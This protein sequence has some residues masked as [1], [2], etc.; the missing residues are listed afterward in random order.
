MKI[1]DYENEIIEKFFPNY[2]REKSFIAFEVLIGG[3]KPELFIVKIYRKGRF[4]Y[5]NGTLKKMN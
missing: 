3:C 1:T 4:K 2:N 5:E